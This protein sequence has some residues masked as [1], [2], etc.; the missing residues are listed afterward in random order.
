[1]QKSVAVA[2]GLSAL[3]PVAKKSRGKN[4]S[5]RGLPNFLFSRGALV[6]SPLQACAR[7]RCKTTAQKQPRERGIRVIRFV[8]IGLA[9]RPRR[10]FGSL[11]FSE[12][13]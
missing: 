9:L 8:Q 2:E 11:L 6:I 5:A 13:F 12:T 10:P 3:G 4:K 7:E 1:M